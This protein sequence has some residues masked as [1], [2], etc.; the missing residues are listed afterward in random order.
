MMAALS[1]RPSGSRLFLL[2]TPFWGQ[3]YY[4]KNRAKPENEENR[5]SQAMTPAAYA[6][7]LG[8]SHASRL[9]RRRK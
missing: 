8:I 2:L 7:Y 1:S 6:Y 4:L 5:A 3:Q 9:K